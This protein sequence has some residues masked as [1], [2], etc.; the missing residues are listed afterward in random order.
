MHAGAARA[1]RRL[2]GGGVIV[3]FVL[4]LS[5]TPASAQTGC[6][7]TFDGTD[8]SAYNTPARAKKVKQ[9]AKMVVTGTAPNP[10]EVLAYL[11]QLELAGVDWTV[12]SG[13]TSDSSWSTT[14]DIADYADR[15]TGIYK[16]VAISE[17]AGASCFGR[18]YVDVQAGGLLDSDAAKAAAAAAAVGAGGV[19]VASGRA[20][21]TITPDVVGEAVTDFIGDRAAEEAPPDPDTPEDDQ[22]RARA[23]LATE[24]FAVEPE[25]FGP[26][27]CGVCASALLLAAVATARAV[28]SDVGHQAVAAISG[29]LR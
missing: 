16:V 26:P 4:A 18:A 23:A 1:A 29:W 22:A 19:A 9:D 5:A 27:M 2:G 3:A 21:R 14:V 15:G 6:S 7:A 11:V 12:D 25:P 17:A 24:A 20:G 10:G 13:T 8:V 28:A